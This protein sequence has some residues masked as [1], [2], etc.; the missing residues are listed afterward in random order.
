MRLAGKPPE[1]TRD[2]ELRNFDLRWYPDA[3]LCV[4]MASNG[5]P[6]DYAKNSEI[7]GLARA[8]AVEGVVVFHSGTA[9]REGKIL[10][11]GGRVL[12]V[13]AR[14]KTV[15]EARERAYRAIDSIDWPQG[16]CR[17]DIAWRAMK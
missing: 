5:Y 14:G 16:F 7:K 17:R 13:T 8:G 9:A 1:T 2:G 11:T 6:G 15:A 3:S 10:A 12:G 4:V